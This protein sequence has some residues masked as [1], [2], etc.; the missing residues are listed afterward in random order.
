MR[1][2]AFIRV[3]SP[4]RRALRSV[5]VEEEERKEELEEYKEKEEEEAAV[6]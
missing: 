4:N 2:K 3:Q 6:G 5:T 1:I